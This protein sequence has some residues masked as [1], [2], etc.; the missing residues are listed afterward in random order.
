VTVNPK[1]GEAH[2]NLAVLYMTSGRK[3]SAEDAL[4]AAERSRFRVHPQLK[5]DIRKMK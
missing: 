4:K 5:E 1:L 3:Q 2:N